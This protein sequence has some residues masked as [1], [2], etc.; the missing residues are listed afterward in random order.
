VLT[1]EQFVGW[2]LGCAVKYL[3]RRKDGEPAVVAWSKAAWF[4]NSGVDHLERAMGEHVAE[5]AAED[6]EEPRTSWVIMREIN[7]LATRL[8]E[9]EAE[10][11][12]VAR[13]EMGEG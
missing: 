6:G 4:V 3:A 1:S 12:R 9:L 7:E 10:H 11:E 8:Q 5:Q 2:C 13:A